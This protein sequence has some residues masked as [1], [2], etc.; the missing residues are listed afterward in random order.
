MT[1]T[2]VDR[3]I[4]EDDGRGLRAVSVSVIEENGATAQIGARKEIIVSGGTYCSPPS[5]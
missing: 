4:L 5:E 1:D 3:V 2:L